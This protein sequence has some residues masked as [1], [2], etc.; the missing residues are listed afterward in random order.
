[1]DS[2]EIGLRRLLNIENPVYVDREDKI[3]VKE[4][5]LKKRESLGI[6]DRQ[7]QKM[8]GI[9]SNTLN[10]IL[11][12]EAKQIN[13]INVIKLSHFLSIPLNELADIYMPSLSAEQIGEIQK[14]KETSYIIENFEIATLQKNGFLNKKM[15]SREITEKIRKFFGLV[16]LYD[17]T[18]TSMFSVFSRPKRDSNE[19]MRNFWVQ[20]ALVQFKHINN[21]NF[22]DRRALVEL[23]PKIRPYTRDVENGLIKVLKALYNVGVTSI[24]QPSL[25]GV[26]V[27]GATM[28]VNGKPCIVLSDLQKNYPTL[29][30]TLLHELHHVLYDFEEIEKRTYHITSGE[31]D[32]FLMDEERADD[33]ARDYL[34]NE[35]RLK[36]A[37]MYI[38]SPV[39]IEKLATKWGMHPSI[40]YS[41]HCYETGE[42]ALFQKHIPKMD[43]ALRLLNTYPFEKETLMQSVE[44]LKELIYN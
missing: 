33:F 20:S 26:Q 36:Y 40:I 42:W 24:Y 17:Y 44:Q 19:L 7:I 15:T 39:M 16:S 22:Y 9:D 10:P 23:I 27:R 21:P 18:K 30:F 43:K 4:L 12:G 37:S 5:Y 38:N 2:F 8:L 28:V 31:G 6:S 32:L 29:W 25:K 3:S 11:E 13:F 14:A 1:M 41:I 35:S 34:L